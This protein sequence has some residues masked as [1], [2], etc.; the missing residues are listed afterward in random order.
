MHRDVSLNHVI[1]GAKVSA[2]R[3][4]LRTAVTLQLPPSAAAAAQWRQRLPPHLFAQA[5][6]ACLFRHVAQ[7]SQPLVLHVERHLEGGFSAVPR[8]RRGAM[9]QA[10]LHTQREDCSTVDCGCTVR[11][12]ED[13]GAHGMG[14][15]Q[16]FLKRD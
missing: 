12:Y 5:N 2:V 11:V 1:K 9:Q 6:G 8:E 3:I 14:E 13:E 15:G 16:L 7:V 10:M 4:N